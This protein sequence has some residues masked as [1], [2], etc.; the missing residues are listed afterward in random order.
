MAGARRAVSPRVEHVLRGPL[1]QQHRHLR[2]LE[3]LEVLMM[4]LR[5]YTAR[6]PGGRRRRRERMMSREVSLLWKR[7]WLAS[8]RPEKRSVPGLSRRRVFAHRVPR[9]M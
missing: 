2:L 4:F 5:K 7:A 1:R 3:V 6:K 9:A 8:E